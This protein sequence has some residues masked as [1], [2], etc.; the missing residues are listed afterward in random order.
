MTRYQKIDHFKYMLSK[1]QGRNSNV[2]MEVID[3]IVRY[4]SMYH[5]QKLNTPIMKT[6][7]RDIESSRY[8]EDIPFILMQ[9]KSFTER[10]QPNDA[11]PEEF[12]CPVCLESDI[13]NIKKLECSHILCC[14]CVIKIVINNA[15]K[16]PLCRHEQIAAKLNV[17]PGSILI[18]T[19][20]QLDEKQE[21]QIIKKA[22]SYL[23]KYSQDENNERKCMINMNDLIKQLIWQTTESEL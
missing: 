9:L 5:I 3:K 16:C 21:K 1:F 13:V 19:I 14:S 8:I 12:E 6:I 2:P 17:L 15:I 22:C 7:L 10:D 20:L 11:K 4:I 18:D 23:E